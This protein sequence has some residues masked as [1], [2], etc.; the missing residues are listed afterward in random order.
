MAN[1]AVV[2]KTQDS[3]DTEIE[4]ITHANVAAS[5]TA[6][7]TTLY[8]TDDNGEGNEGVKAQGTLTIAEPVTDGDTFTIN[9]TVFELADDADGSPTAGRVQ[10]PTGGSEANTKL[11]IVT[12]I[13]G[14]GIG[15]SAAAFVGDDC[16]ITADVDGTAGN[17]I[18]TT[19]TFTHGSNVFDAATLGT[20][21]AG[22]DFAD[23][24]ST[25]D[26]LVSGV[27]LDPG[28]DLV[29]SVTNGVA[30]DSLDWT[31]FYIE[32]DND[33]TA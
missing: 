32:Y 13:N 29:V 20:T 22:V 27:V 5:T 15:V 4:S 26:A 9:G 12:A 25:L 24:L 3:G 8:A 1:R 19:E 6:K 17:S 30:G 16:V 11:N 7:R 10:V 14:Q 33:P 18:A 2:F 28:E 23:K 31:V 21:T